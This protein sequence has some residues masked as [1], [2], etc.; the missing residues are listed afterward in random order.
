MYGGLPTIASNPPSP[1]G[2]PAAVKKTSGNSTSQWNGSPISGSSSGT[3]S[4]SSANSSMGSRSAARGLGDLLLL[5]NLLGRRA[6]LRD[7]LRP[8]LEQLLRVPGQARAEHRLP[9]GKEVLNARADDRVSHPQVLQEGQRLLPI[10]G[11]EPQRQTCQLDRHR[12]DVHAIDASLSNE[13]ADLGSSSSSAPSAVAI[14]R[15]GGD[16]LGDVLDRS[17]QE[18]AAAGSGI[19]DRESKNRLSAADPVRPAAE[20]SAD[21]L[22][23]RAQGVRATIASTTRSG[24]K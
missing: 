5:A 17:D 6:R 13:P 18:V 3:P 11:R 20:I 1:R 22:R 12:V 19:A 23:A 15:V 8:P 7:D 24:V 21:S 16:E 4:V 10:D 2:R 9:A 14:G